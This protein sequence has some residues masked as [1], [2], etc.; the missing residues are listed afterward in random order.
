VTSRFTA[1]LTYDPLEPQSAQTADWT[2][3]ACSLAWLNRAL[4]IDMATDEYS[5]VDYIGQ[6]THINSDYG[7]MD[8]SGG[9]LVECLGEQ[10]APAWNGWFTWDTAFALA[11]EMPLLIGG[12]GWNHWVGVR[13]AADYHLYLANSAPGWQGV[14]Q[15]LVQEQY[16]A[17]GPMAVVAVP[18]LRNFPP[19]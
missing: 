8:A 15:E 6:P 5:A 11:C 19:S 7:L 17:L 3:S 13:Y 4:S 12:V 9:R 16:D 14:G 18:L 1:P 2:C 10:G